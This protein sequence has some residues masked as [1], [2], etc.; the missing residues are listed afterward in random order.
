VRLK[1]CIKINKK[2]KSHPF[3]AGLIFKKEKGRIFIAA[4]DGSIIIDEIYNARG[5]KINDDVK[6]GHRLYTPSKFLDSALSNH[7]NYET[8]KQI[9]SKN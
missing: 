6:L 9:E 4:S 3:Q 1:K 7:P 2:M 8:I 5:K